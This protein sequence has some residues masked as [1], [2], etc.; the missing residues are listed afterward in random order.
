M[1]IITLCL[2]LLAIIS[3]VVARPPQGS[4]DQKMADLSAQIV[5]EMSEKQKTIAIADFSMAKGNLAECGQALSE[6]L[7]TQLYRTRG[8]T[9]VERSQLQKVIA[10]QKLTLTGAFAS[11]SAKK[12]GNL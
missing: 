2:G 4:L 12:L 3:T 9:V 1:K 11:K 7:I 8:F 5:R 10:E 6:E